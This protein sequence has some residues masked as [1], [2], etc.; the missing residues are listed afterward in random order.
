MSLFS[1]PQPKLA[2]IAAVIGSI[3]IA[4]KALLDGDPA[5]NPDW[6]QVVLTITV[7]AGLFT[8]RQNNTT[9]EQAGA[10]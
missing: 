2:A 5:T 1:S 3:A 6:S 8:T 4:A 10:K 7:A 9:S